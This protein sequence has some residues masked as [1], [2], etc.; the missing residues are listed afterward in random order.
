MKRR[1]LIA[2]VSLAAL[3]GCVPGLRLPRPSRVFLLSAPEFEPSSESQPLQLTVD[4]PVSGGALDGNQIVVYRGGHELQTLANAQWAERATLLWQR[5]LV[6]ALERRGAFRSVAA[7]GQSIK[8]DL[9]LSGEIREFQAVIDDAGQTTVH[10]R[11]SLRLIT[12]PTLRVR[13]Q[14]VFQ[15]RVRAKS[16]STDDILDAFDQATTTL[17]REIVPWAEGS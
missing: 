10:A 13:A 8:A 12:Q 4:E 9:S 16:D 15:T 2:G 7:S 11:I 3:N 5:L 1:A 14:R 17:L 6:D